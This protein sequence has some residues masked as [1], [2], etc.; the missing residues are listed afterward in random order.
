MKGIIFPSGKKFKRNSDELKHYVCT[1]GGGERES[2]SLIYK[3]RNSGFFS[4]LAL[5]FSSLE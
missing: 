2:R 3:T 5:S 4:K 1:K